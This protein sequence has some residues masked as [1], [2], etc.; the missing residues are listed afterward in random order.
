MAAAIFWSMAVLVVYAYV[1]YGGLIWLL[2]RVRPRPVHQSDATPVV[3][4]IVVAFNEEKRIAAR[5]QNL[6]AL[7][8]SPERLEIIVVSDGSTDGTVRL[9]R[10]FEPRVRV[11]ACERRR[12]KPAVLNEVIP[13]ARGRIVVLADARQRFDRHAVAAL[14]R[15]FADPSVGAVSGELVLLKEGETETAVDGTAMYWSYEKLIRWSESRFDSSVGA[16][17]AI[18]ALRRDLFRPIP[19]ATVLDDVLIP[20]SIV[21]Q[22]YR[23]LFEPTARAFDW[24]MPHARDEFGRKVRTL[25]GN[26]QLFATAC[27]LL[28]PRTNRLWLQTLSH[29]GLRLI[30]PLIYAVLLLA[31]V[32][33]L[34]RW[35]YRAAFAGETLFLAAA[36]AGQLIPRLRRAVPVIVLPYTICFLTWATVIGFLRF[37]TGRQRV[38]WARKVA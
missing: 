1:G 12:G 15:P 13:S 16:T 27:W 29:K 35:M 3:S 4:V 38:T 25:A 28:D 33:L 8:Y 31:N 11:I 19:E 10:R 30:L 34:D 23:V 2:A 21:R 26:F 18:Y 20:M 7:A 22:G 37:A 6:L 17:G 32:F 5:L 24:R 36:L 9:A 14:V